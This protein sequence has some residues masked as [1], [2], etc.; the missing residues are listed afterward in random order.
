MV[1]KACGGLYLKCG[2]NYPYHHDG[3]QIH[4]SPT[5]RTK[6]CDGPPLNCEGASK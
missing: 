5:T 2:S 4:S 6:M 1:H 3:M